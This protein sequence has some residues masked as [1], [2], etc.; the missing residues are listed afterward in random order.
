MEEEYD[1]QLEA[2]AAI[3][4]D[5][6]DQRTPFERDR[7]RIL[8]SREF[9]RLKDV[10]QVARTGESYL[11]HDRL[12]HSLKVA[13]VG[14]RLAELLI[15]YYGGEFENLGQY[16]NEDVVE[17]ACLAHDIG[18]P[19]FGHETE[20]L[21][22]LKIRQK[23]KEQAGQEDSD[24]IENNNIQ[25]F[26]GNAQSFRAVTKLGTHRPG[27]CGMDLTR[28][29]LNAMLKYPWKRDAEDIASDKDT[30]DKWGYYPSENSHFNFARAGTDGGRNKVI[31]AEVMDFAD[32]LTYAIHDVEDFYRSGLLP[33]DQLLR[34]AKELFK[35][36]PDEAGIDELP[37]YDR[38][39][40]EHSKS[41]NMEVFDFAEY[42]SDKSG[43]EATLP[44]VLDFLIKLTDFAFIGDSLFTPYEGTQR[45]RNQLNKLISSLIGWY[46]EATEREPS[47]RNVGVIGHSV[48]G[49]PTLDVDEELMK[50]IEILKELT[51]YYVI[52]NPTLSAQ[53]AGQKEIINV[54]FEEL[55]N[56]ADPESVDTSLIMEPYRERIKNIDSEDCTLRARIVADL[57]SNMTES[58]AVEMRN[59]ITGNSPG[60]LQNE[61]IRQ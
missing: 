21:L 59:R 58:Q 37:D 20:N 1:S 56:E 7:D 48:D 12:T 10:T 33:L 27:I 24:D 9:R 18:H 40:V 43:V 13:Q 29:T 47:E 46:I 16:L 61:I 34:E 50:E 19:P 2:D 23:S 52:S 25:G 38:L 28:A 15:D 53:Q 54:L 26:E 51:F 44:E 35:Q 45:E 41:H 31:E 57:I 39:I 17:A 3:N 6:S 60:S 36:L 14:R 4:I 22:D 8:Y 11:Y 49:L 30:D 55:Y 5:P 32:D 42:V